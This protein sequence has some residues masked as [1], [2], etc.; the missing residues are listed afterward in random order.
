MT[1]K[2]ISIEQS[3][4]LAD[5]RE[6]LKSEHAG[7]AAGLQ[8]G[9]AHAMT[10]GGILIEAKGLVP[11]GQ[12]LPWLVSCGLSE[13]TAQRYMRLARHRPGIEGANA[14]CV[15]DLS[16]NGA[17]ALLTNPSTAEKA[18]AEVETAEALRDKAEAARRQ[19]ILDA[20]KRTV[21]IVTALHGKWVPTDWVPEKPNPELDEVLA[22]F[23]ELLKVMPEMEAEYHLAVES[24]DHERAFAL[25]SW[26]HDCFSDLRSLAERMNGDIERHLEARKASLDQHLTD[27]E[28]A[29][30][31]LCDD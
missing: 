15:S 13:R 23:D 6:R 9:L 18:L 31:R 20:I 11:H 3:N 17:L 22:P 25:V 10:A 29:D 5:L 24:G 12:W 26:V 8:A 27:L 4:S 7:V 21:E 1:E 16:L 30:A 14:T 19:V 28:Q 2:S